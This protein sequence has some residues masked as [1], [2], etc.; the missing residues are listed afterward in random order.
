MKFEYTLKIFSLK[1]LE[2]KGVAV[3]S[4]NNLIYACRTDG[5]CEVHDVKAE[6]LERLS[7]VLNSM[8]EEGWELVQLIFHSSGII[9]FW[10]RAVEI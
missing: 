4:E 1:E 9:S 10:K 8:G 3:D 5:S 7:A 6:Q 2:E